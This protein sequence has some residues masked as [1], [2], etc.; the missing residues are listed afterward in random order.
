MTAY[1]LRKQR[2]VLHALRLRAI[3]HGDKAEERRLNDR[4]WANAHA[5]AN[6]DREAGR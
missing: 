3:A 6:E 5:Q 4:L 1:Q 2:R